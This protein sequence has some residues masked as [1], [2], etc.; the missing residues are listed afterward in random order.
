MVTFGAL[1][2]L[3]PSKLC[4]EELRKIME[5]SVGISHVQLEI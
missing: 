3:L 5:I 1:F 4:R 2:E